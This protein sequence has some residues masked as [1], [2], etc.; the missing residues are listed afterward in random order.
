MPPKNQKKSDDD[1]TDLAHLPKAHIFKFTIA[2]N[3]FYTKN[4]RA[5]VE[6]KIHENIVVGSGER[7]KLVTREDISAFGKLK[8]YCLDE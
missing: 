7:I 6:A 5:K 4:N 8:A 2:F 3:S 1:F